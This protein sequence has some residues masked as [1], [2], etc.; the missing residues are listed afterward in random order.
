[1]KAKTFCFDELAIL[2]TPKA[3]AEMETLK[4]CAAAGA[5]MFIAGIHMHCL[6]A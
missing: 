2:H 1:M 5:N 4:G 6:D 3:T